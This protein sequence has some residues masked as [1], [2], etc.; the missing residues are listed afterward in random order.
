M[1]FLDYRQIILLLILASC[2]WYY[3]CHGKFRKTNKPNS[4]HGGR[5][6]S[7]MAYKATC[8]D[9]FNL[10]FQTLERLRCFEKCIAQDDDDVQHFRYP[11]R[12]YVSRLPMILTE[13]TK[14]SQNIDS[15]ACRALGSG[16]MLRPLVV[17]S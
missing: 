8:E 3:T 7:S 11:G 5:T 15:T 1:R 2:P 4:V 12:G 17:L 14:I 6:V 9:C 16:F 10:S 13:H